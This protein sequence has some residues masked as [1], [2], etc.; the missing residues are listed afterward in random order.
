M[1]S[2]IKSMP[3]DSQWSLLE[4][5]CISHFL[6]GSWSFLL[7]FY[8]NGI[9]SGLIDKLYCED[10]EDNILQLNSLV[11]GKSLSNGR[12]K[13]LDLNLNFAFKTKTWQICIYI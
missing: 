10:V 1:D 11:L 13:A 2:H 12:M 6:M 9:G 3:F 4:S 7:Q 5:N 8:G